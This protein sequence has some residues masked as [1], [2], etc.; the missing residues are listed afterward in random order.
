MRPFYSDQLES[1]LFHLPIRVKNKARLNSMYQPRMWGATF[2]TI[3]AHRWGVCPISRLLRH[4]ANEILKD[5]FTLEGWAVTKMMEENMNPTNLEAIRKSL[6]SGEYFRH[7]HELVGLLLNGGI[8]VTE[9][10]RR[11]L[12]ADMSVAEP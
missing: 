4:I 9:E 8:R 2:G 3:I 11:L 1:F 5:N 10:A 7:G 6:G 12:L